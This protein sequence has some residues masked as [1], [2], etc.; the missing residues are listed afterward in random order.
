[1]PWFG[2]LH[3]IWETF[4]FQLAFQIKYNGFGTFYPFSPNDLS[5]ELF[6]YFVLPFPPWVSNIL[7]KSN[8]SISIIFD[9]TAF[10]SGKQL[11]WKVGSSYLYSIVI[12]FFVRSNCIQIRAHVKLVWK[13]VFLLQRKGKFS[14]ITKSPH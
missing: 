7:I 3:K 10:F 2:H 9:R 6:Y 14:Q 5:A 1:M 12:I 4:G 8:V 11:T 13:S